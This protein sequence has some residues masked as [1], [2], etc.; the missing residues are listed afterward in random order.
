MRG[1]A[2]LRPSAPAIAA[3]GQPAFGERWLARIAH[4]RSPGAAPASK[5]GSSAAAAQRGTVPHSREAGKI[6]EVVEARGRPAEGEIALAFMADHAVGRVDGLVERGAR[7]AADD[8]PEQRRDDAVGIV[9]GKAL[10]GGAADTGLIERARIAANDHAR[11]RA[12][13]RQ[14]HPLQA[15]RNRG[16]VVD[17]GCVG[18]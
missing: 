6:D 9:L 8:Q 16:N 14:C 15:R 5:P 11:P 1:P 2:R 3:S 4:D 13:R 7:Q 12:A 17:K 18:R 10:D